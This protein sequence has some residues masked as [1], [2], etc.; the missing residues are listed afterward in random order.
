MS[1]L[2]EAAQA[3]CGSEDDSGDEVLYGRVGMLWT[4]LN[5]NAAAKRAQKQDLPEL[6]QFREDA[7]VKSLVDKIIAAGR[8]GAEGFEGRSLPLMWEWH[9]KYYLGA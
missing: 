1:H 5:V 3:A 4:L 2:A 6:Q 8:R 7:A 9:Y